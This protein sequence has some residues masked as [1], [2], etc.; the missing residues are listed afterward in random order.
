MP[1]LSE[2]GFKFLEHVSDVIVEAWGKNLNEAFQHVAE[3]FFEVM[4]EI[5]KVKPNIKERIEVKGYDLH[6][7]LYNW[8]ESLLILFETKNLVFSKFKVKINHVNED[9]KLIAE[10]F[11]E[12][13]NL[14]KHS[15]KV[16]VKAVTF[17]EMEIKRNK[18]WKVRVLLDI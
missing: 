17:H 18:G 9:F 4:V 11:G 1:K 15:S 5:S 2:G 10:A 3:G 13:Y 12:E 16:A 7:L 6:S 8:L 14:S